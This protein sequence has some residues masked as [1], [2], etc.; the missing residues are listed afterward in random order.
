MRFNKLLY[1]R[2]T[3]FLE[4]IYGIVKKLSHEVLG[5]VFKRHVK[6]PLLDGSSIGPSIY[7]PDNVQL[8]TLSNPW[9]FHH[10]IASAGS[11]GRDLDRQ[12]NKS[13][14]VTSFLRLASL[15]LGD[16]GC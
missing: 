7:T 14:S 6:T 8:K 15:P 13:R 16:P 12:P 9:L 4:T 10:L 2:S 3:V 1:E 5:L 11:G